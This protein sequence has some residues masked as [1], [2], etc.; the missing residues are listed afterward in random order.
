MNLFTTTTT[1]TFGE[2]IANESYKYSVTY[3]LSNIISNLSC[4]ITNITYPQYNVS[5]TATGDDITI[6]GYVDSFDLTAI[7]DIAKD[8]FDAV[9]VAPSAFD[10]T[11][12]TPP[13]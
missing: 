1:K 12:Y 6:S 5:L 4:V 9:K 8:V 11:T 13:V 3:D 7:T 10:P 2:T